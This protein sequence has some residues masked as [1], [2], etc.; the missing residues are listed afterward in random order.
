MAKTGGVDLKTKLQDNPKLTMV[1]GVVFIALA[2]VLGTTLGSC[3]RAQPQKEKTEQA[4]QKQSDDKD[5]QRKDTSAIEKVLAAELVG[6]QTLDQL[7]SDKTDDL[8]GEALSAMGGYG[9]ST[10]A[11]QV[12][13]VRNAEPSEYGTVAYLRIKDT[14]DYYI[15]QHYA[16]AWSVTRLTTHV[17]GIN[18]GVDTSK[19]DVVPTETQYEYIA[20]SD[21][22]AMKQ[23]FSEAQ[24]AKIQSVCAN[25]DTGEPM[26]YQLLV[27]SI[28][29]GNDADVGGITAQ[30]RLADDENATYTLF[31]SD[32]ANQYTL[33]RDAN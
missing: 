20:V 15:A 22:E 13:I 24:V 23:Y 3:T 8:M 25:P 33:A 1:I 14:D 12:E 27:N 18:D 26:D 28:T 19:Y 30:L 32:D 5:T 16:G 11:D 9:V 6:G 10:T 31:I 29:E 4:D 2:I 21:T 7:D 17:D